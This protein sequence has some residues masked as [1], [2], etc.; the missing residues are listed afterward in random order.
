MNGMVTDFDGCEPALL[1]FLKKLADLGCKPS[2]GGN[3]HTSRIQG[4]AVT[5][6]GKLLQLGHAFRI[7]ETGS[8]DLQK[9]VRVETVADR[10]HTFSVEIAILSYVDA[11]VIAR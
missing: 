10:C 2:T 3:P 7:D 6:I 5:P 1:Q 11:K 9:H 8:G 4:D